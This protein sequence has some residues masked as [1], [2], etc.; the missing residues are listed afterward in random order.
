LRQTLAIYFPPPR[1][2]TSADIGG[3]K[4]ASSSGGSGESP[5]PNRYL[6][7]DLQAAAMAAATASR[8]L[9]AGAS[10]GRLPP[11][12]PSRSKRRF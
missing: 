6:A 12:Q 5:L 11:P 4:A 10:A 8:K 3:R 2:E 7:M 9:L 1:D